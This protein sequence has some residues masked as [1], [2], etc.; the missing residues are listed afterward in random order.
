[1]ASISGQRTGFAGHIYSACKAAVIQMTKSVAIELGPF[2]IRTNCICP[3]VVVTSIFGK[4][5]GFSQEE[6]ESAYDAMGDVFKDLQA[7]PRPC[8]AEDIAKAGLW[9]AS[10]DSGYV[11]GAALNVDGGLPDGVFNE[12]L[13]QKMRGAMGL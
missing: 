6:T 5:A 12:D 2:N 3:G 7:I 1:M 11:N 13:K 4:G 8:L 10:D 9:L